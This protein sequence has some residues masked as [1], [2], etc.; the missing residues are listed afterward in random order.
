MDLYN[1]DLVLDVG[2]NTGQYARQIREELDY[3]GRIISFEPLSKAYS[4]LEAA[5]VHDPLWE[6]HNYALGDNNENTVINVSGNSYSSSL[7]PML[8]RHLQTAPDSRYIDREAIVVRTLDSVFNDHCTGSSNIW[9]KIDTQGYEEKIL[10]GSER[11]LPLIDS[12]QI[13]MSLVPL[14]AG[15]RIFPDMFHVMKKY[16][17]TLISLENGICDQ[18]TGQLLQVDGIY[19]RISC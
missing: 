11:S 16:G 3:Q 14:Y 7:L 8:P 6:C 4:S 19:H 1:V 15:E 17:Y 10:L 2:A 9:M 13:E 12:I 5:S 18:D